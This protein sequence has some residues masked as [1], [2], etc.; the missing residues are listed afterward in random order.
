MSDATTP[1]PSST[2]PPPGAWIADP[3]VLIILLV[4]G[5]ALCVRLAPFVVAIARFAISTGGPM[6]SGL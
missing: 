2:S 1:P 6:A 4:A 5:S 3:L